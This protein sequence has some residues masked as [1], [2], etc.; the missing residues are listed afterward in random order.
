MVRGSSIDPARYTSLALT[1]VR[2][3]PQD[4]FSKILS[5]A[6]L[7]PIFLLCSYITIIL[8]R[9][10]LTFIN[11][12]IGQLSCEGLNW[13][14]KRLIRQPRPTADFGSGYGMPSSHSQFLGFFAA[15]FLAHFGLN[16]PPPMQTRT[17]VGFMRR[18]EH[19]AAMLAIALLA[20]ITCYSRYHLHYHTPLQIFVGASIGL[21]YGA[22][23][24][25][26]TEH[27]TRKALRL[28][29]PLGVGSDSSS[30]AVKA[31]RMIA[32]S[33]TS[34]SLRQRKQSQPEVATR[35]STASA[36]AA[37]TAGRSGHHR[38]S[39]SIS[40]RFIPD[41]HPA[42]PLRQIILDHPIAV[43][44]RI[45]D[46]WMVWRDG[47]I[48]GEYGAW[49]REWK[50]RRKPWKRYYDSLASS[51]ADEA[52]V[53]DDD[54]MEE[55][56]N[57]RAKPNK[58]RDYDLM[59]VALRE[60]DKCIP[61]TTA[62][63]VGCVI[64]IQPMPNE[65]VIDSQTGILTT[66]YSRELPGNTHAEQC[67]LDKLERLYGRR[68]TSDP[69][70]G[71]SAKEATIKLDLYT[72]MEPC[73]ER[74][75]GNAPCVQRILAFNKA[76]RDG[77]LVF[78]LPVG[79]GG[80]SGSDGEG[81]SRDV[82]LIIDRVLQGVSEPED[83]VLCQGARMLREQHVQVETVVAPPSHHHQRQQQQHRPHDPGAGWT[84]KPDWLE[85]ECLRIAKKGHQDE[86][87]ADPRVV[88]LWSQ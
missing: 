75:S 71:R 62:F 72:T 11:A 35:A 51:S 2:Y 47:G 17:V 55:N 70:G 30:I 82:V 20:A 14:L 3:D 74:L 69:A 49:Q 86:P 65:A 9:R 34:S 4:P 24:Y 21:V 28:P 84:P 8:Y 66:G 87:T 63:C 85:K 7:S 45:R 80:G 26:L 25:Y 52:V 19:D 42:P 16:R 60:A 59:V 46:S 50:K 79:G 6:T 76:G 83:F 33:S 44:F 77:E 53:D 29:A 18:L 10:E 67:A 39:S 23:Y 57:L 13:L 38:R 48:E 54:D 5:L 88:E 12:L 15:F 58:E 73:S 31:N 56:G 27:L 37:K 43:A 81:K 22:A 61:L 36:A 40:D 64:A 68:R 78:S 41:L 32:P 1:H